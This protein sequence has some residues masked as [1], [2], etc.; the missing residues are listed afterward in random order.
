MGTA[1]FIDAPEPYLVEIAASDDIPVIE[2]STM[3]LRA[4]EEDENEIEWEGDWQ[5]EVGRPL[6]LRVRRRKPI[7]VRPA[8]KNVATRKGRARGGKLSAL[9]HLTPVITKE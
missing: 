9:P 4:R 8:E 5:A 6:V 3:A 7:Q 2:G 1:R